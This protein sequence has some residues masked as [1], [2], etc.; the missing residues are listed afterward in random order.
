MRACVL[1][2]LAA[3]A[4]QGVSHAVSEF[5]SACHI[6]A[7]D[8]P[9]YKRDPAIDRALNILVDY[10]AAQW[11]AH[12]DADAKVVDAWLEPFQRAM[13]AGPTGPPPSGYS[14]FYVSTYALVGGRLLVAYMGSVT[15]LRMVDSAWRPLALPR[16]FDW[17]SEWNPIPQVLSN[18]CMLLVEDS[19]FAEGNRVPERLELLCIRGHQAH[20]FGP[21][22]GETTLDVMQPR[23]IGNQV[24]VDWLDDPRSFETYPFQLFFERYRTWACT[25]TGF[26]LLRSKADQLAMRSLDAAIHRAWI[27][28][29]PSALQRRIRRFW[30]RPR[31]EDQRFDEILDE[32]SQS[33]LPNGLIRFRLDDVYFFLRRTRQGYRVTSVQAVPSRA[34]W[35]S[36]T[37]VQSR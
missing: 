6:R 2:A 23:V 8:Y 26:H 31:N 18:G 27:S 17:F 32:W 12:P 25:P 36:G 30:P 20:V 5:K 19:T 37:T 1:L 15:K 16:R 34:S 11:K 24:T 4:P 29:S 33:V 22:Q 14:S 28:K 10:V 21:L 13:P 7:S 35:R 3:L 9:G